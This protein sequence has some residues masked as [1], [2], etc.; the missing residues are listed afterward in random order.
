MKKTKKQKWRT[1]STKSKTRDTGIDSGAIASIANDQ[2]EHLVSGIPRGPSATLKGVTIYL[3][4]EKEKRGYW[5]CMPG[6]AMMT[7]HPCVLG[8]QAG[9]DRCR[10]WWW[11]GA[12]WDPSITSAGRQKSVQEGRGKSEGREGEKEG[13]K[14]RER[15]TKGYHSRNGAIAVLL[16]WNC[17]MV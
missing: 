6:S 12:V 3:K 2:V 13:R 9:I 4:T 1:W 10:G 8:T 15:F 16:D 17:V 11:A 14:G 7:L 5:D